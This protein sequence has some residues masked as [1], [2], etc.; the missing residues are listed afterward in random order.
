V[1]KNE[2]AA[3][4]VR[5]GEDG[6]V[7]SQ[8]GRT[9]L[10][11]I[12]CVFLSFVIWVYVMQVDSPEHE[13]TI[14]AVEV[15]LVNTATLE[16]QRNL[17]VYSG[18]G[19]TVDVTVIGQ[20]SVISKIAPEDIKI[21]A[22]V[23]QITTAGLHSV[24]LHTE[25]PTGLSLG[26]VSQNSIQV[27]CDEKASVM[28]DV[29]ARITSFTME[30]RLEMGELEVNYDT[31]IVSGPKEALDSIRNA[32]VN[33]ELGNISASMTASGKLILVDE[34]GREIENP[35][36]RMSRSDVTVYVPVYITKTLPL[37]VAYKYG[38]FNDENVE[39]GIS[40]PQLTVRG[41][42]DVL[43]PMTEIVVATLDEKNINDDI[44]QMVPL[45]LP[46]SISAVDGRENVTLDI[47]LVNTFASFFRVTDIDVVGA[48]NLD[49]Q[50]LD[51]S[52]AVQ[53][54][55]TLIDLQALRNSDFSAI[56]DLS[57]YSAQSSG[58]IREIARIR[59]DS[60]L[61]KNVYEIGE[62]TVQ[63]KLN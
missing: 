35:Y 44:I 11:K 37:S 8:G 60:A 48:E 57:G 5:Y 12:A 31:I 63:V 47:K 14:H 24:E 1:K 15:T 17:S 13:E 58:V 9:W 2:P 19:N 32:Q 26:S 41:D 45:E 43:D 50:I 46:D 25:L 16:G 28:V 18:Y 23:S 34:D 53:V 22:D 33:L 55:G 30:S 36:L 6:G 51:T 54:R 56:V 7:H 59:I 29:R 49:Y 3:P 61:S 27:Y 21:T 10:P 62:Y 39:I 38:Y 40:P 52:I 20:K 4:V 42:P